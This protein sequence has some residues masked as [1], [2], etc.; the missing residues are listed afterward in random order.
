[1]VHH[2]IWIV[3]AFKVQ[4]RQPLEKGN[5]SIVLTKEESD[6]KKQNRKII[7]VLQL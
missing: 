5:V 6:V 4:P 2:A 3:L 7:L 1:M